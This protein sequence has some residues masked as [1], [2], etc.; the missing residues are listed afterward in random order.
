MG[1]RWLELGPM[2]SRVRT[3]MNEVRSRREVGTGIELRLSVRPTMCFGRC[4]LKIQL[5]E[6]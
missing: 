4:R 3:V 1:V 5:E 6:C 2:V